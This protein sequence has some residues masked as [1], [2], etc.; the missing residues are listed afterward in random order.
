MTAFQPTVEII[1]RH[2]ITSKMDI[3]DMVVGM[4]GDGETEERNNKTCQPVHFS[5]D[6][7]PLSCYVSRS[8]AT[9]P[10]LHK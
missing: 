8:V 1:L 6:G 7:F 4:D 9:L 5:L 3:M 2:M 10:L